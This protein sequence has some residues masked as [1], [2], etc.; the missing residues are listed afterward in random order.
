MT[1]FQKLLI[2]TVVVLVL[3]NLVLIGFIWQNRPEPREF[4]R[5]RPE[6][7]GRALLENLD[8]SA[9]QRASFREALKKHHKEKKRLEA[10]I[11]QL[12]RQ[13]VNAIIQSDSSSLDVV[14]QKLFTTQKELEMELQQFIIH[15][16]SIVN[17][18]Q[19]DELLRMYNRSMRHRGLRN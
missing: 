9:E 6:I 8:L 13:A 12:K 7:R 18:D 1:S 16:T 10:Q 14:N 3:F 11:H 5:D 4:R 19:R 17:E 2:G 15:L